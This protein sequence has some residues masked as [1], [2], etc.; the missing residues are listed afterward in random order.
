M[1]TCTA[2]T[3]GYVPNGPTGV[4]VPKVGTGIVGIPY[5]SESV[6]VFDG[7]LSEIRNSVGIR[8]TPLRYSVPVNRQTGAV[9]VVFNVDD[10]SVSFAH[11]NIRSG[12]FSVD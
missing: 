2:H 9:D 5:V 4:R 12:N 6:S 10:H 1:T 3:L 8:T 11:L 7:A